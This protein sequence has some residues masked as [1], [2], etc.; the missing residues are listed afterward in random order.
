MGAGTATSVA[1]RNGAYREGMAS[2]RERLR[3]VPVFPAETPA[4]DLETL[5]EHPLD[6]LVQWLEDALDREVSQLNAAV[7]STVGAGGA[8]A[9]TLLLKDVTPEGVWFATSVDSPKGRQLLADPRCALTLYWREV[10]RQVR[11]AGVAKRGP[12]DVSEADFLARHPIARAGA[13]AGRQSEPMPAPHEVERRLDGARRLVETHPDAV[14]E[15]WSAFVVEPTEVEFWQ[16]T[17]DRDQLRMR[18]TARNGAFTR[19]RLWP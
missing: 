5:P 2:L 6:L 19:E 14:P 12:R 10:G 15:D 13:L 8:Q 16:S 18:Y 7:L 4:F 17:R 11:I 3:A 9:R 1:P